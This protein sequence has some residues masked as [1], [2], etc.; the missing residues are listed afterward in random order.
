M[1][2]LW[3]ERCFEVGIRDPEVVRQLWAEEQKAA[4]ER[5]KRSRA[6]AR[7]RRKRGRTGGK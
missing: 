3:R 4:A 6:K 1:A 2:E 5:E 7:D